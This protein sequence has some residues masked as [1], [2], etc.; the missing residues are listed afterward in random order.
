ME[1]WAVDPGQREIF[2]MVDAAP[3]GV[4]LAPTLEMTPLK[5]TTSI[6]GIG[7]DLQPIGAICD[8]CS[9]RDTCR[10]RIA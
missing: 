1:G 9:L 4:S 6:I 5:S 3:L 10:H 2:S 7:P 8:Y